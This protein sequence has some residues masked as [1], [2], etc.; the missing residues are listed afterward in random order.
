MLHRVLIFL[1]C[2]DISMRPG[3]TLKKIWKTKRLHTRTSGHLAALPDPAQLAETLWADARACN[4]IQCRLLHTD[5]DGESEG[6]SSLKLASLSG[7]GHLSW[8]RETR[9]WTYPECSQTGIY[10]MI[11]MCYSKEWVCSTIKVILLSWEDYP[12]SWCT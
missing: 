7:L 11:W 4:T 6:G 9:R 5:H 12:I 3:R 10:E 1:L 8:P 2:F